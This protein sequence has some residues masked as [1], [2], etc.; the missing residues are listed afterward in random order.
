MERCLTD[1]RQELANYL[2]AQHS[3][4]FRA[5]HHI[6]GALVGWLTRN[7]D[8]LTN[9]AA[10]MS[11]LQKEGTLSAVEIVASVGASRSA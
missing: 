3:V 8:D 10:V 4:P 5:T 7:G 2:V 9:T 11:H 6:V 1:S